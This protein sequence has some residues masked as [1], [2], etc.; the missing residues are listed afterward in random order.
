MTDKKTEFTRAEVK[1]K[2]TIDVVLDL[3][4]EALEETDPEKQK[5]FL[6][7]VKILSQN[8]DQYLVSTEKDD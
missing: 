3:Y 8:I 1:H 5:A 2:I 7:A 4:E 6:E